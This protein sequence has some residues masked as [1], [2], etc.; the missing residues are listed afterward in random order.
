VLNE[1]SLPR[2]AGVSVAFRPYGQWYGV[3]ALLVCLAAALSC[4]DSPRMIYV[5]K[6]DSA[7]DVITR[8]GVTFDP[9]A[10]AIRIEARGPVTI[11]L[12]QIDLKGLAGVRL[13]FRGHLR[14]AN[15]KGRAYFEIQCELADGPPLS[16]RGLTEAVSGTTDWV[17]Q[18][19]P[20]ILESGQRAE[21]VQLNV[22][23]EGSGTLWV[24][25]IALGQAPR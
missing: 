25:V 15:L 9:E 14:S 24:N 13:F 19:T 22:V 16:A 20:L 2:G 18:Q 4:S 8:S 3:R 21:R 12:A 1:L 23:V 6:L 17:R 5:K 10:S 7:D 11:H